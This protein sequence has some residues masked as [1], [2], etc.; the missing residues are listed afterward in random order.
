[1]FLNGLNKPSIASLVKID[2][3]SKDE[4]DVAD[5]IDLPAWVIVVCTLLDYE[6]D[7]YVAVK[8]SNGVNA[9]FFIFVI[10][11]GFL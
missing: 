5:F 8:L 9:P 6:T 7:S 11:K 3:Y 10:F 2:H 1:M 4:Y